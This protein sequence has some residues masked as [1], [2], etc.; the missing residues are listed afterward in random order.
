MET[1]RL[2]SR[3]TKLNKTKCVIKALIN[4]VVQTWHKNAGIIIQ[5][6]EADVM[7]DIDSSRIKL[8]LKNLLDNAVTHSPENSLPTEISL[9]LQENY[10]TITVT[11]HGKGIEAQHLP[12]LTEPF[13]RVDPSRQRETGGYGL[14]LYL[15]KM[16]AEAHGGR[17][18]IESNVGTGTRVVVQ[19]PLFRTCLEG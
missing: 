19:L 4:D 15:C 12:N 10:A 18:K 16:I 17:L 9:S 2:S 11:D 6:P 1:E 5:L 14:G 8:L 13:Y 7:L 3:H